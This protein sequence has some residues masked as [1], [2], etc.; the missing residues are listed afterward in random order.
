MFYFQSKV[1]NGQFFF[2]DY[3][4]LKYLSNEFEY[5]EFE[6]IYNLKFIIH[7]NYKRKILIITENLSF[8]AIWDLA[9]FW[10]YQ[11]IKDRVDFFI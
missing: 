6:K 5:G 8:I 7:T 1:D 3:L 4:E 9:K 2:W 11:I 10:L